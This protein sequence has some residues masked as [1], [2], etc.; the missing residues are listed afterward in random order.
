[1]PLGKVGIRVENLIPNAG[2]A[3]SILRGSRSLFLFAVVALACDGR[4]VPLTAAKGSTVLIPIGGG[5]TRSRPVDDQYGY[6]ARGLLAAAATP[7]WASCAST[8]PSVA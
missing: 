2:L 6:D 5:G 1:M 4:P 8:T 7:T 3:S